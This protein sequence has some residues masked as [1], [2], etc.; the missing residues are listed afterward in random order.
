MRPRSRRPPVPRPSALQMMIQAAGP[1]LTT[2]GRYRSPAAP[3]IAAATLS[4]KVAQGVRL[5]P[6]GDL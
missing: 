1:V 5:D 2:R 4:M 3:W 6:P